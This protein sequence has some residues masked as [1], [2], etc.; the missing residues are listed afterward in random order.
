[1]QE[2]WPATLRGHVAI[3]EAIRGADPEAARSAMRAHLRQ[4]LDVILGEA[5]GE[6]GAGERQGADAQPDP[7]GAA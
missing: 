7:A 2:N 6:V 1:M 5:N 3:L 4:V